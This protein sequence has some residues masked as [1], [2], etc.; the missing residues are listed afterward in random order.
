[1]T[2]DDKTAALGNRTL[3]CIG[4]DANIVTIIFIEVFRP[5]FF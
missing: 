1:M 2:K 5:F 4:M 3:L